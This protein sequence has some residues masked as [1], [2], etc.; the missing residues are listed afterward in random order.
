MVKIGKMLGVGTS[1]V[2]RAVTEQPR[3][4]DVGVAE[5]YAVQ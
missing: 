3:P 4:F 2:Q 5:P 1:N